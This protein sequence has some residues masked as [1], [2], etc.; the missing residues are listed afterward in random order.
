MLRLLARRGFYKEES[1]TPMEFA[2]SIPQAE[3]AAPVSRLTEV[4]Q[5]VRFGN[6]P[7]EPRRSVE[8]LREIRACVAD[9]KFQR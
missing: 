3:L 4:Y 2:A 6:V 1:I 7:V 9:F 5:A 8:L